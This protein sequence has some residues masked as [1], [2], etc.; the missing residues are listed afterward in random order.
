MYI[1]HLSSDAV[2]CI[3]FSNGLHG[4][5]SCPFLAQRLTTQYT[6]Y[7]HPRPTP[8][9]SFPACNIVIFWGLVSYDD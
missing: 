1:F 3:M 7:H 9:P 8:S 2:Q 5:L 4:E 6:E